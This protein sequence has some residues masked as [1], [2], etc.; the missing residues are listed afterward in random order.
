MGKNNTLFRV[1]APFCAYQ[2]CVCVC[3]IVCVLLYVC[4]IVGYF[5]IFFGVVCGIVRVITPLRFTCGTKWMQGKY[6]T[7]LY[8][9]EFYTRFVCLVRNI[10]INVLIFIL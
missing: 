9:V 1:L 10:R 6:G 7:F 4:V 5:F 3:V 8:C 2:W